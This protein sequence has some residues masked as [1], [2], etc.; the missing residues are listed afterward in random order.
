MG[1]DNTADNTCDLKEDT[2]DIGAINLL[3]V[4]QIATTKGTSDSY[5]SKLPTAEQ[6]VAIVA[7][8][9]GKTIPSNSKTAHLNLIG[10]EGIIGDQIG[11]GIAGVVN[12]MHKTPENCGLEDT[13]TT[14][15]ARDFECL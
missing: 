4:K 9:S 1:G 15:P 3:A 10:A 5:V 7:E 8:A 2:V 12:W 13:G 11:C 14:E 6:T